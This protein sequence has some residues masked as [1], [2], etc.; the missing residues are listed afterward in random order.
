MISSY[1]EKDCL[2]GL[3]KSP[4]NVTWSVFRVI[5]ALLGIMKEHNRTKTG[6]V[7]NVRFLSVTRGTV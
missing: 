7:F 1:Q 4:S 2:P 6:D 5:S 3:K